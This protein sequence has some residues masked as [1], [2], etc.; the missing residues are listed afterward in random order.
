MDFV[1]EAC[2]MVKKNVRKIKFG[3]F[4]LAFGVVRFVGIGKLILLGIGFAAGY[5]AANH[6]ELKAEWA[7]MIG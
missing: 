6:K 1:K 7:E 3:L 5:A 4:G 2:E